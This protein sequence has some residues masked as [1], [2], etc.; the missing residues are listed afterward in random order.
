MIY[1][2]RRRR[3]KRLTWYF[4]A[5]VLPTTTSSITFHA[6][7]KSKNKNYN[8]MQF[9]IANIAGHLA[10]V[11]LWYINESDNTRVWM[12]KGK[13]G[14]EGYRTVEFDKEPTGELLA[15]LQKNATPL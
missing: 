3:K 12:N 4:N 13:W 5:N 11:Q 15:F 1:N 2:M 7:F 10:A 8:T 9:D 14:S 6:T